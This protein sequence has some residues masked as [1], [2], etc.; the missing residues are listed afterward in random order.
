M[1][2]EIADCATGDFETR[3]AG[4]EGHPGLT[5]RALRTAA[6]ALGQ[7]AIVGPQVL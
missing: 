5:G 4:H 1:H 7:V 2:P 3:R 6:N